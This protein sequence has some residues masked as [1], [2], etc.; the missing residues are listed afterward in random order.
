MR[1]HGKSSSSLPWVDI[2]SGR[3][4]QGR[5][6]RLWGRPR[7]RKGLYK[8]TKLPRLGSIIVGPGAIAEVTRQGDSRSIRL[9]QLTV[10]ADA[11]RLTNGHGLKSLRVAVAHS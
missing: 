7:N 2:F 11:S 10:L 4:F 5:L 9:S 3:C 1:R 8:F 6:T